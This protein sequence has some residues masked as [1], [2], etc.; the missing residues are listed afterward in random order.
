MFMICNDSKG[1]RWLRGCIPKSEPRSHAIVTIIARSGVL[2][3]VFLLVWKVFYG[4]GGKRGEKL[5]IDAAATGPD[6]ASKSGHRIH[7]TVQRKNRYSSPPHQ[8][9]AAYLQVRR[10]PLF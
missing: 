8:F 2:L 1:R 5:I 6:T 4:A 7:N 3:F 10:P 9:D